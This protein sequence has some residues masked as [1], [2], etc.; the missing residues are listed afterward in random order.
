M[1]YS[2]YHMAMAG[3]ALIQYRAKACMRRLFVFL[4]AMSG[5]MPAMAQQDPDGDDGPGRP[6]TEITVT[7]RRLDAAQENINPAL[8]ASSYALSNDTVES[9]PGGETVTLS[10]VLLQ[11][12]GVAQDASG[13]LRLRQSQGALQYRI[14]NVI[15]PDGLTDPGDTL[16]AR[17]ASRVELVTGA[18]P[19]Q[20]GLQAGGVVN[21]TTKDGVYLAGGQAEMY[22]GSH[23]ML[24]PAIEYG[25]SAGTVNYFATGQYQRDD[26]GIASPDGSANPRHDRTSQAEGMV[27]LDRVIGSRDRISVILSASDERFQI[28]DPRGNAASAPVGATRR[29]ANRFAVVS[30]LHTTGNLTMQ[31]AGFARSS[32]A[33]IDTGDAGDIALSGF[34]R[35]SRETADSFGVQAEASYDPA[36]AHTLRG[37]VTINSTLHKGTMTTLAYPV[38]PAGVSTSPTLLALPAVDRSRRRIDSLFVQDEWRLADKVTLNL[39]ERI[40]HVADGR[41][42]TALSPR[43]NAIWHP[44][45]DTTIH[46]GYARYFLPA[47]IEGTSD[48]PVGLAGTTAR[49]PGTFSDAVRAETDDYYDV[50]AQQKYG[51]LTLGIDGYWRRA[52]NLLDAVQLA[53]SYRTVDFNYGHGRNRGI[54]LT[55]NYVAQRLSAWANREVA[56][57]RG[58][59]IT[60]NQAYFTVATLAYVASH[61]IAT[62]GAQEVTASGGV[63]YR[64]DSFRLAGDVL[65]GSGLP[66]T[67]AIGVPD[68]ERLP[69]YAQVNIGA[70]WRAATIAGRPLD[71]RA[72]II[73]LFDARYR[74]RDGTGLVPGL[75]AW[76]AR[77]GLFVGIEQSF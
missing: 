5:A 52:T 50:G 66:R 44:A 28:P 24:E 16:S 43:A 42:H 48:D 32:L 76:G 63:S 38:D 46:I 15:L 61:A 2:G 34:G 7:A 75:V 18:L 20:Y 54:E 9:R 36:E 40:D 14:N 1:A 74:L 69:A 72:D 73:N 35:T 65:I 10:Q 55:A 39:G 21:I 62:S 49:L 51:N 27:Y 59:Q 60:S 12:P 57:A 26:V 37:G 22:G 31:V 13:Q 56:Q 17:L 70:V 25:G 3:Q 23:G 53:A 11:A 33:V 67:A 4:L 68:G 29:D 41:D 8:G 6:V 19:A 77:R 71:L 47:P 30:L 45:P 64:W 58:Q